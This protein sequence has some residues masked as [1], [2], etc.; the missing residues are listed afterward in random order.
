MAWL[1]RHRLLRRIR[2]GTR[3]TGRKISDFTPC[4]LLGEANVV[5]ALQVDSELGAHAEPMP[6]T[7]GGAG[8]DAAASADDMRHATGRDLDLP[9]KLG[10][11]DA[12]LGQLLKENS[13][14]WM[15]GRGI[16]QVPLNDSPRF[17]R[18]TGRLR[19][20]AIRNR[21]ATHVDA[22]AVLPCP[23]AFQRLE[24][25]AGQSPQILNA[26]FDPRS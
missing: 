5:S 6:E 9:R 25:I 18:W 13:P 26:L 11:R 19:P 16:A 12:K 22:D 23:V 4:P 2:G 10:R 14:G 20:G 24:A 3:R 8:G 15:A 21:C 17:R 7:K 1:E